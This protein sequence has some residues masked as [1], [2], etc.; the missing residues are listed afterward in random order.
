LG[1]VDWQQVQ[2]SENPR[3]ELLAVRAQQLER[4]PE[5]LERAAAAK[6]KSREA[7]KRYFDDLLQ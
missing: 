5:D 4:R 1:V 7:N 3:A 6:K 2:N